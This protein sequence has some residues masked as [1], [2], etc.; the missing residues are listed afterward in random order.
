MTRLLCLGLLL[1]ACGGN[2]RYPSL[3]ESG[4]VSNYAGGGQPVC[5]WSPVGS[6]SANSQ[7]VR[8]N[9]MDYDLMAVGREAAFLRLLGPCDLP[10]AED[11][12][13]VWRDQVREDSEN[14]VDNPMSRVSVGSNRD[15]IPGRPGDQQPPPYETR[16]AEPVDN[17]PSENASRLMDAFLTAMSEP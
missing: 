13:Q 9:G 7:T 3:T 2:K 1:T 5:P 4:G 16:L 17:S 15:R 11:A 8:I 14:L 6:I 12:F 10:L